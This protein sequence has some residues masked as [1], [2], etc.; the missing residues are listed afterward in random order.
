MYTHEKN[1]NRM[2]HILLSKFSQNEQMSLGNGSIYFHVGSLMS[3][4]DLEIMA[5]QAKRNLLKRE[6]CPC[7]HT[8]IIT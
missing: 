8:S 3:F 2:P 5:I 4:S 1:R 6:L 7:I